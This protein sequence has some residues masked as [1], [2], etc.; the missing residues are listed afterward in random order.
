MST[1][2]KGLLNTDFFNTNLKTPFVCRRGGGSQWGESFRPPPGAPGYQPPP[3]RYQQEGDPGYQPPRGG[4]DRFQGN[5]LQGHGSPMKPHDRGFHNWGKTPPFGAEGDVRPRPFQRSHSQEGPWLRGGLSPD[6]F[7]GQSPGRPYQ[8]RGS[9]PELDRFSGSPSKFDRSRESPEVTRRSQSPG[10]SRSPVSPTRGI[11]FQRTRTISGGLP[12][13]PSPPM[14]RRGL[15]DRDPARSRGSPSP[16]PVQRRLAQRPGSP[17]LP[18]P[19]MRRG[20]PP[21]SSMDLP[22][23]RQMRPPSP[24]DWGRPRS[25]DEDLGMSP[26]SPSDLQNVMVRNTKTVMTRA[27]RKKSEEQSLP[28]A[29]RLRSAYK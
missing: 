7:P 18:P 6:S 9:S 16:P 23:P 11:S 2:H 21:S 12:V 13:P 26:P 22:P 8:E 1:F 14:T 27:S 29:K 28:P 17:P 20:R 19:Q 25:Q 3:S 10:R 4:R 5:R 24:M 15:R